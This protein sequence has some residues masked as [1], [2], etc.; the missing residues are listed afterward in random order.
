MSLTPG[1]HQYWCHMRNHG[2]Q[3]LDFF[4]NKR[5]KKWQYAKKTKRK[6]IV[7]KGSQVESIFDF[8]PFKSFFFFIYTWQNKYWSIL[9]TNKLLT[10]Q[11]PEK[12]HVYMYTVDLH[13]WILLYLC[14]LLLQDQKIFMENE[15]KKTY[16]ENQILD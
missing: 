10:H 14:S 7:N 12:S 3:Q 11:L 13:L 2:S 16:F 4:R 5:A 9:S 1:T 6:L 8:W 15:K